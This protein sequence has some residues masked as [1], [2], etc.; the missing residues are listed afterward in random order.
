MDHWAVLRQRENSEQNGTIYSTWSS[1]S[2]MS[3]VLLGFMVK[4]AVP[5]TNKQ[6]YD[7]NF[8]TR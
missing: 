7:R 1:H 4:S 2:M 6:L 5:V 3:L 8:N